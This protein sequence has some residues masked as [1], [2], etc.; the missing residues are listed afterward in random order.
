[1]INEDVPTTH[2]NNNNPNENETQEERNTEHNFSYKDIKRGNVLKFTTEDSNQTVVG[3]VLGRAGKVKGKYSHWWNIQNKDTGNKKSYDCEKLISV[4]K[5]DEGDNEVQQVFVVQIPR[6]LHNEPRCIQAKEKE[7][8]S[9]DEFNVVEEVPDEGQPTLGTSWMLIEKVIEGNPGV[10]ARLCVRGD[11]ELSVFRTDSPTVHKSSIHIFFMLAANKGW[12]VQTADIK[13]AF[14]QGE[15]IDRDVYLKPPKERRIN[16]VIWKM[17]KPAYGL[18]DASRKFYLQFRNELILLGCNQSKYDPAVYLYF[19]KNDLEGLVLTHVDD[20]MHGSGGDKFYNDIMK[21]LKE[22]FKFG[23][24]E[25]IEFRYVGMQVQQFTDFITVNQDHYL[26]VMEMPTECNEKHDE[27]LNEDGQSEFRSML[28]RI[29]WLGNH[30]RPDLAFDHISMSTKLGKAT[31]GD[32]QQ[33]IK[34]TKKLLASTTEIRFPCLGNMSKW[35]MEVFA[36]AGFQSLPDH[37]SSCGGQVVFVRDS[38]T[39]FA[40]VLSWKARK[41]RRVVTSSTAAETLALN[42]VIS[43]VIFLKSLLSEIYGTD[44]HKIPTNLYTDSKNVMKAVHST[45]MV[46]DP[47]LRTELACIKESLEKGEITNLFHI[48]ST[49]MLANCM[50]KKGASAK[51]LLGVLRNG[52]LLDPLKQ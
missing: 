3:E 38:D 48:L 2:N 12:K 27:L 23:T 24:E 16:G 46:D 4:E 39:N 9:W 26:A 40:C 14:L 18:S 11:Q 49:K 21:P 52:Y 33:A 44:I 51:D 28:G 8:S 45:S 5:L 13:C 35:V 29:G 25:A 19:V 37:M 31:G 42:E 30:S 6:Y 41:L 1:M 20:L 22:K 43:E 50:T 15:N 32:L 34:V 7:L 36:D 47:R 17:H 10:K